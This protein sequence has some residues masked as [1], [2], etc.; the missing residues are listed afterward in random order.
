MNQDNSTIPVSLEPG[1]EATLPVSNSTPRIHR[2][3]SKDGSCLACYVCCG[4]CPGA[5]YSLVSRP[6]KCAPSILY[7]L[8]YA[9]L[10]QAIKNGHM[11]TNMLGILG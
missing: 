7:H 6:S 2:E 8:H 5:M 11:Q 1:F 9:R 3:A 10:L 4:G